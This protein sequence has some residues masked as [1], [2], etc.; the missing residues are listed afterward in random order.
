VPQ[1]P[2]VVAP[3]R[4]TRTISATVN[5]EV[6]SLEFPVF[7]SLLAGEE[8]A[9]REHE[10]QAVVTR[11]SSRLADAILYSDS[12]EVCF[13]GEAQRL[14]IRILST[15]LGIPVPLEPTEQRI[16]LQQCDLIAEMTIT[17]GKAHRQQ[18]LRTV[19]AAIAHRL[20]GCKA[21]TEADSSELPEP[22]QTAIYNFIGD[23]QNGH[24]PAKSPEELIEG[25]VETLGKLAP[26]DNSAP[27]QPIGPQHS[28]DAADSGPLLLSSAANDSHPSPS[29][30]SR[31]RSRKVSAG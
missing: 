20:P 3:K 2:F 18:V 4:E 13:E 28:G 27:P 25:M 16:M 14:A 7:G 26:Q 5:G 11:E 30:T 10:Y 12:N 8:I 31:K 9:I 17:L 29:P 1:L 15:R 6:C 19:T 24:Q 23:E 22:L 21:W